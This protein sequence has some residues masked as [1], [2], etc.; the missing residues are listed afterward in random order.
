M[1]IAYVYPL[2]A[3]DPAVQSGRPAAL[4]D[5]F[6]ACGAEIEPVFPL[7]ARPPRLA[8]AKKLIYRL[9]FRVHRSDRDPGYLARAAGEIEQRLRGVDCD[10]VF[11]PGSELVGSI[12]RA[13]RVAFCA[14]ATFAGMHGYYEDFSRLSHEYV[15]M[16]YAQER[17]ALHRAELAA[18][19]SEWAARTAIEQHAADPRRV[20]VIPFGANLGRHNKPGTVES[21]ITNR[22]VNRLRLLFVGRDWRRK[23]GDL[24]IATARAL[25]DRGLEIG[26]D[27]VGCPVPAQYGDL[28]W[29]TAHGRLT[30][31]DAQAMRTLTRL[32]AEAHLL[33]V[34]S[35]AEAFG[36]IYAEAH[37]HG[38]PV[39]A[40]DTGGI[41]G[42]VRNHETGR[43]L[44]LSSGA[45]D[46]AQAILELCGDVEDYRDLCRRCYAS[47]A[48]NH[49]WNEFAG[50]FLDRLQENAAE[51]R[52]RAMPAY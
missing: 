22:P 25:R 39:L 3:A 30:A 2:N 52:S 10:L 6:R 14:D 31:S 18:Y 9:A 15:R 11:S 21:W 20:A 48:A 40:T 34:P 24:V 27:V 4:L 13:R 32:Y 38:V 5:A 28:P 36:L 29:V 42:I 26:L 23:G 16:G 1:R 7:R 12:S 49:N 44:P 51:Q 8:A 37:A 19:P 50:R 46:F 45:E 17:S 33:F 35:R 47:F 43:L 41:P